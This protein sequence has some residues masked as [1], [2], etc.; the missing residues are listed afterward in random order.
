MRRFSIRLRMHGA[1]AMVLGLFA[2]VGAIGLLGGRHL[3]ELNTD[4]MHHSIKEVRN[5]SDARHNL[6][7]VRRHEKDM[8][9]HMN[10]VVLVA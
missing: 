6:G 10:G 9:I 3:A 5:V 1:I 7:E 8:V 4:F 2:L